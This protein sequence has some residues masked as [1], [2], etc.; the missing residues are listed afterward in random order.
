METG[1]LFPAALT[2]LAWSCATGAEGQQRGSLH[3]GAMAHIPQGCLGLGT[4]GS[5]PM[6]VPKHSNRGQERS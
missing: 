3:S 1:V 6:P 2:D 5:K 4:V